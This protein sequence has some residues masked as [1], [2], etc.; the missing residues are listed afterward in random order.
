MAHAYEIIEHEYDV[1]VLGAGGAGLRATLGMAATGLK[2]ACVTKVFPTRSHT[3][4]AQ[5]G[6]GAALGNMAEDKWQWHMY[7]TVKGSDWL[8]DQ[9][10]IE[11]MCRNAIPAVQELEH[12]G[13]P[14][15]RT[16][17]GKIYQRP[18]GGHMSNYGEA[19]VQ[20]ACA[21]ADRTGHAILHT[22]YSQCLKHDAT[23]FVEYI[24]IDLLMD[25]DGTC[26]GLLAWD[27]D[28][29]KLHRFRAHKVVLATGGYGR[30][31]FSCTSAHTCTGDGNGMAARAGIPLQDHEFVQ[32]HPTGIYGSGCLITE[33]ARGEGGYLTNSEGERFMPNYAPTAKDLASRDVVSRSMAME[34]RE[35]RGV[36]KENDHI[37]LHL[38]HLPAEELWKR[39]PGITETAKIFAGVDATKEPIPVLPTVHYNMGGIPT[40][41]HGEVIR[42]TKD[43][44][45]AVCEGLMAIGECASASVHGANRLGTNSLLDIVVFGRAAAIRCSETMKAGQPH[46]AL[47]EDIT[48]N[49]IKR[50]DGLRNANGE[51]KTADVRLEMQ[52]VMQGHAAVFRTSEVLAEGV[53]KLFETSKK[54]ESL[55]VT[56]RSMVWN[57]DLVETLE[58]ENLMA[59]AKA[60]IVSADARKES[61]GAHAHEDFP[62]RDDEEWMKHTLAYVKEDGSIE[63][64][65]RPVH[66]WTLTDEVEYIVPKERVY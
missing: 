14:F 46:K 50:F 60:T 5:G 64:D 15:S 35:G 48:D 38:E 21:A 59:C 25:E 42:P 36:G 47:S 2:T 26:R 19:P 32:F 53:E 52:K 56:D 63:L 30:A 65:Y 17:E 10:A 1:V 18:F 34:I 28:T 7:D 43:D 13:V 66:T 33:G 44:P 12:F 22:L 9:D 27:L 61:R 6:V 16:E 39:L 51:H 29:G 58:L 4:A 8:G 45:D 62:N 41:Y 31:F 40:N 11:Y 20:R 24:G 57:S 3:V 23:F 49:I 55:K 37:Y 54:M